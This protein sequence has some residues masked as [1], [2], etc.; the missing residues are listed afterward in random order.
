MTEQSRPSPS[1]PP[2][3]WS[4]ATGRAP[5]RILV[6]LPAATMAL[7]ATLAWT[8]SAGPAA[9]EAAAAD[10]ELTRLLRAMA[11]IKGSLALGVLLLATWRLAA[12]RNLPAV[13]LTGWMAALALV[14]AGPVLIWRIAPL[15]HGAVAFHS[16]LLLLMLVVFVLDRA[17]LGE[18]LHRMLTVRRQTPRGDSGLG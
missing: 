4:R 1:L 3:S 15:L 16:G 7:S 2:A 17:A 13:A 9:V 5:P 12:I 8:L 18:A 11:L 10:P 6:A 14:A